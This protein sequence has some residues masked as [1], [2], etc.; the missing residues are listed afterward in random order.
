MYI[1]FPVV[2]TLITAKSF[3]MVVTRCP[4]LRAVFTTAGRWFCH[5]DR[6]PY[7]IESTTCGPMLEI[8]VKSGRN[9]SEIRLV[10]NRS[11]G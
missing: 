2:P 11:I 7:L 8:G 3:H 5:A 4:T 9:S 6:Y 10:G 1:C